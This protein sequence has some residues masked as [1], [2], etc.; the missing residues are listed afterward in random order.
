MTK[1]IIVFCLASFFA[2]LCRA[3]PPLDTCGQAEKPSQPGFCSTFKEI[4]A[5]HCKNS[6]MPLPPRLCQNMDK[7][8][9]LMTDLYGSIEGACNKQA[10]P[11]TC[12]QSWYCY[13][14]GG[15]IPKNDPLGVLCSGTGN[16]CA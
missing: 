13:R 4:A 7:I 8:Y 16:K 3:A 6:G 11:Q 1:K 15:H 12:I 10:D 5:C 14:D 2:L 9:Q